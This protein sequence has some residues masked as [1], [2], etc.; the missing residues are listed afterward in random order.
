[1]HFYILYRIDSLVFNI[2]GF[3]WPLCA[4][5]KISASW[6][7]WLDFLIFGINVKKN[8]DFQIFNSLNL[9][10][11]FPSVYF[12]YKGFIILSMYIKMT[13]FKYIKYHNLHIQWAFDPYRPPL[14]HCVLNIIV[15]W[16]V[17]SLQLFNVCVVLCQNIMLSLVKTGEVSHHPNVI[18]SRTKKSCFVFKSNILHL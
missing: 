6:Q 5:G 4:M 16:C 14:I 7:S 15:S 10:R 12:I 11:R 8:P 13:T 3:I 17:Y 2:T 1:M 9:P 18:F